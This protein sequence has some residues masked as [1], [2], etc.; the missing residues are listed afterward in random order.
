[1]GKSLDSGHSDCWSHP[2][3]NSSQAV[4]DVV[5]HDL[6]IL[7]YRK[8]GLSAAP[9][10][11]ITPRSK[12]QRHMIVAP[13]DVNKEFDLH[14]GKKSM[15]LPKV[16][17]CLELQ[18]PHHPPVCMLA[19]VSKDLGE[20]GALLSVPI[21]DTAVSGG[22]GREWAGGAVGTEKSEGDG[23]GGGRTTCRLIEDMAGYR[24]SLRFVHLEVLRMGCSLVHSLM[25]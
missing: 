25:S 2:V 17:A 13:I 8:Q 14:L 19:K 10:R 22:K 12:Q 23:E 9:V 18:T 7:Q 1:M 24:I 5:A 6:S 15:S 21:G 20:R 4:L 16:C 3:G 11:C